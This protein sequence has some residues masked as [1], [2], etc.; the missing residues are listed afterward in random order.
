MG[1]ARA[2]ARAMAG[3]EDPEPYLPGSFDDVLAAYDRGEITRERYRALAE[4][5]PMKR[6]KV[7][8]TADGTRDFM[9]ERQ[10]LL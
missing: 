6:A 1:V 2:L 8:S 7:N 4:A 10:R 5:V 9:C 3:Q